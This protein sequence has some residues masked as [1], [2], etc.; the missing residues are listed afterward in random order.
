MLAFK[1]DR[2]MITAAALA[3]AVGSKIF[4]SILLLPLLLRF[5][6]ARPVAMFIGVSAVFYLP[7]LIWIRPGLYI[8]CSSSQG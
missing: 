2:P 5:R 4:P 1:T 3:L 8:T 6:S 7:W